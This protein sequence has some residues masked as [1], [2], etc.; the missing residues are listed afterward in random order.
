MSI[1][2]G[3]D[4]GGS[5]TKIVGFNKGELLFPLIVKSSDPV[6]SVYGA[7]GK[8]IADNGIKLEDVERVMITG[9]GSACITSDIYGIEMVC[10]SE[11]QCG[12]KGG[13]YLSEC[14]KAV[15]VSLGTGTSLV[16]AKRGG[17]SE[18]LGGTGVGGG[19][20][21]GLSR[22]MLGL[23]DISHVV[24]VATNGN[25][26]NIDLRIKD[27]SKKE[28]GPT[29]SAD[30]TA[31]NFGKMSDTATTGDI[32]LGII[33]MIYETA[34]MLAMFAAR[35]KGCTDI[36]LIGQLSVFPQAEVL[37]KNFEKTFPVKFIIP[38]N[39]SH[40]TAIGAALIKTEE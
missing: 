27:I 13:L 9:V 30:I 32:A 11:F 2:I 12:A 25:L 23:N 39:A 8:F 33:N 28:I 5:T 31:S 4:V 7:F 29:L 16:Y 24:D 18:Y 21:M 14:E 34:A 37:F 38:Q 1:R 17:F 19:T 15:I 6:A 35:E 20:L 26:E 10:V 40:A 22:K 36:I 3:I